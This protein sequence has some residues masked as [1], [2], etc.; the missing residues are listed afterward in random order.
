MERS[1][2]GYA[3]SS[4]GTLV[5]LAAGLLFLFVSVALGACASGQAAVGS[6]SSR[7]IPATTTG[8]VETT[9]TTLP[10]SIP[11]EFSRFAPFVERLQIQGLAVA[12]LRRIPSTY[13]FGAG[14]VEVV[15]R[16]KSTNQAGTPEDVI[17]TVLV[18]RAAILEK[19][20]GTEIE[21][22]GVAYLKQSGEIVEGPA[23]PITQTIDPSWYEPAGLAL[24]EAARRVQVDSSIRLASS[25]F[26]IVQVSAVSDPYGT[27]VLTVR[28]A[29]ASVAVA[30]EALDHLDAIGDVGT[31]NAQ[32][33][34]KI[35]VVLV[36]IETTAGEPV[37]WGI[38]DLQLAS[39]AA[40]FAQGL[41]SFPSDHETTTSAGVVD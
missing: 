2:T 18:E 38:T 12:E 4:R 36:E 5:A 3:W 35:G 13:S 8:S 19:M 26:E 16:S 21:A 41:T 33:E 1:L 25:P 22:I 27:R 9:T 10:M 30:N 6:E 31:L 29:V 23:E 14:G 37:L 20:R 28:L 24:E 40:W 39:T 34:A 11:P 17:G 32:D 7:S 15:L